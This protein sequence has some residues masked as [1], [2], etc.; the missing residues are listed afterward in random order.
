MNPFT[1]HP[2]QQ[3]VTYLQH[4][5]FAIGIAWR[6]FNSVSAFALHALFPFIDI[7][8]R[9]D[10]EATSAYLLERNDW[11]NSASKRAKIQPQDTEHAVSN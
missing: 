1:Q 8:K 3:G 6:L 4:C 11:I 2:E 10:L 9:L 5:C 7:K